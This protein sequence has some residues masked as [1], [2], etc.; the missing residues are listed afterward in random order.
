MIMMRRPTTRLRSLATRLS[1]TR[2]H[3]VL[4]P[5]KEALGV[6]LRRVYSP[7]PSRLHQYRRLRL[8]RADRPRHLADSVHTARGAEESIAPKKQRFLRKKRPCTDLPERPDRPRMGLRLTSRSAP[9]RR[10]MLPERLPTLT[11]RP[12]SRRCT[13]S[14][15]KSKRWRSSSSEASPRFARR[16]RGDDGIS[17]TPAPPPCAPPRR[18][19]RT[20]GGTG[21][22]GRVGRG[23]SGERCLE[24]DSWRENG[25]AEQHQTIIQVPRGT[26]VLAQHRRTHHRAAL[27]APS[28]G[29]H[30][31]VREV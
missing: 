11:L 18:G 22:R 17:C 24:R 2:R 12:W 29:T 20:R 28:A 4:V 31:D 8:Q 6:R 26:P 10:R 3:W 14:S 25:R 13:A 23:D 1:P 5:H 21:D 30:V 9:P 16:S 15:E 19:I 7:S 27:G